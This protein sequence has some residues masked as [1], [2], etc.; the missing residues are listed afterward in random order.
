MNLATSIVGVCIASLLMAACGH[1]EQERKI[2]FIYLALG[3]SDVIGVGATPL[4]EGYVYL[5][6]QDLQQRIPG[7]FLINLGL[8][9]ARIDALNEQVRLAKH[10]NGE[11]DLVTVWVGA[12]D[13][14]HGDDPSRFQ[15][16][17]R[18]FLRRLQS[19]VSTTVV[20]ANLPDLTQLPAFRAAN[21]A[22]T[23]ARVKAFNLAIEVEAP[24]VNASIVNVF[25]GSSPDD[26][27]VDEDGFHPT[28]AGHQHIANLFRKAILERVGLR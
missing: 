18:L 12:N 17:L 3:T 25:G 11:A 8:P 28:K 4:T 1:V 5:I 10:F 13:L 24:Y 9:G 23:L 14:I 27:A 6:N 7:T 19:S 2:E 16:D 15:T 26:F 22:V 21:P 20:I